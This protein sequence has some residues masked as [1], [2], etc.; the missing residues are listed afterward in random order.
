M[1][2][3]T[4]EVD[5]R[6]AHTLSRWLDD[7]FLDPLIGLVL[8]GAGD[9]VSSSLGFYI[10]GLAVKKGLGPATIARM[11]LNLAVDALIGAVPF[12]GDVFDVFHK[13]NKKNL[14]LLES[15]APGERSRPGDW[16]LVLLA[17][18]FLVAALA[19]PVA[20]LVLA[21]RALTE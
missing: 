11:L 19:L 17:G 5:T 20:M 2:A 1:P 7:R 10:V 14:Q 13:A 4:P 8:P 6:A 15:R 18:L 21:V 9:L 3:P 16:L 12:L